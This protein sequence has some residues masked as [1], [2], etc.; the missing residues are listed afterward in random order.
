MPSRCLTRAAGHITTPRWPA[1]A[2]AGLLMGPSSSDLRF[3]IP[4]GSLRVRPPSSA[5]TGLRG[6]AKKKV[7]CLTRE[8]NSTNDQKAL[9]RTRRCRCPGSGRQCH[10]APRVAM[11]NV[12]ANL[13]MHLLMI[14]AGAH[15]S[16]TP[17]PQVP[18]FETVCTM[19]PH[20]HHEHRRR[21]WSRTVKGTGP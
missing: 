20:H 4:R 1:M 21:R 9:H 5:P 8:Y 17:R 2:M 6:M 11:L 14:T 7:T 16:Q 12:P 13:L 19:D 10:G 18:R 15:P 3:G